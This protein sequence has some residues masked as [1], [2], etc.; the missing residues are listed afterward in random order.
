MLILTRKID[1]SI[2]IGD[3]IEI[4]VV[5]VKGDHAKIGIKAPRDVKIYRKEVYE[6]VQEEM[7][8][9]A[10]TPPSFSD[11]SQLS[12]HIKLQGQRKPQDT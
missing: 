12:D 10:K 9:A 3:S 4:F 7:R 5:E 2:I 8:A 6:A 11:L 1:E